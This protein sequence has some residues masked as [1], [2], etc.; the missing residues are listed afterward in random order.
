MNPLID[1]TT[2]TTDELSELNKKYTKQLYSLSGDH[3]LYNHILSLR[4]DVQFEYGE[5]MQMIMHKETLK[6]E[7]AQ[8]INIGEIESTTYGY[9]PDDDSLFIQAVAETYTKRKPNE[10]D[11]SKI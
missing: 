4:E 3:P 7:P 8:V 1:Y 9:Q 2:K 11:P 6:K 10:D 5:R